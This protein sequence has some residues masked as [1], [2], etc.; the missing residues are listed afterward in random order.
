MPQRQLIRREYKGL[1]RPEFDGFESKEKQINAKNVN[2]LAED[3]M[4]N[5]DYLAPHASH[6]PTNEVAKNKE[7]RRN[8]TLAG[9]KLNRR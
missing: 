2:F 8:N 7:I 1:G 4:R 5:D 3:A 9:F 6:K